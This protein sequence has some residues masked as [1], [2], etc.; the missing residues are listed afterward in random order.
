MGTDLMSK[1]PIREHIKNIRK[2]FKVICDM[3]K[4]YLQG[5]LLVSL[6]GGIV[7]Y[8]ELLLSAYILDGISTGKDFLHLITV[9]GVCVG[10]ILLLRCSSDALDHW[11]NIRQDRIAHLY[12][13]ITETKMLDMDYSRI[14][15]PEIKEL[16]ARIW[17][18]NN[19]GAGINTIFW[20]FAGLVDQCVR[21]IIAFVL[22]VPVIGYII[23][24][25]RY[26]SV[27]VFLI[28][29][30][31]TA[32]CQRF[33]VRFRKKAMVYMFNTLK[34]EE[35]EEQE[36]FCWEF[37]GEDSFDYRYGKDI[38][39]YG[40][41][42]LLKRWTIDVLKNKNYRKGFLEGAKGTAGQL[43]L[44]AVNNSMLTGGAY[45]M[46]VIVALGGT[47]SVGSVIQLSGALNG[48]FTAVYALISHVTEL[49]LAAR[50]QV[51][52]LELLELEDE[53]Y[54]GRLPLE[55]RSDNQ[56]RIEF[57]NVSFQYPGR[58]DWALKDFSLNLTVGEKLA[59]VGMN[60][61]G[62]TTMIKLLCRLYD[63][64][65]GE[66]LLNGVDIKKFKQTDYLRLFSVVFQD[67]VLFPFKLGENVAVTREYDE[68][69]VRS[70]LTD[71]DF[72]V[73]L[74][75]LEDGVNT[76]LSKNYEDSGV[77]TSGG[78]KQKI[79]IARAIYKEAPFILLDEPTAALD[80]KA[81]YEIYTNFDRIAGGKTAIYISH[82]LS[83]CRFCEKIA[84][85][86]EGRLV[87][88]GSHEELAADRDGKYY[89]MW[90][91]QAQYYRE[92]GIAI[93]D[94]AMV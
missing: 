66:I 84:V 45:L 27:A 61:S 73:R 83:S 70:C 47:I 15:S 37:S 2:I 1:L 92:Q 8:I 35:K 51:S 65:Q 10:V 44:N 14:D 78:E 5:R 85:F 80:P 87:Q 67:Y 13:C 48:I 7:P 26:E 41:Y 18:D 39:I 34:E 43:G 33:L 93:E 17:K 9:A 94:M 75:E 20:Q 64:Q 38:R 63:P 32:V 40:S 88:M 53:M 56:Y 29:V 12:D 30:A 57:R 89:E 91:A 6:L 31:L 79:A 16:K 23:R 62:K 46:V 25:K 50:K 49:A 42:D 59:I 4:R 36:H 71:A 58:T 52:T 22:A 55:K 21:F 82:R 60:G 72:G 19:W 81:E 86:H 11:L 68:G 3:D 74:A 24:S 77:E 76:Y 28:M 54:K 69:K 90:N